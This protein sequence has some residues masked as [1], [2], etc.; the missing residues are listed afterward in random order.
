M[1]KDSL[2]KKLDDDKINLATEKDSLVWELSKLE[3]KIDLLVEENYDLMKLINERNKE[4]VQLTS[5]LNKLNED[6][7]KL[8][9]QLSKMNSIQQVT[10]ND[11]DARKKAEKENKESTIRLKSIDKNM[12]LYSDQNSNYYLNSKDDKLNSLDEDIYKGGSLHNQTK[13]S[14]NTTKNEYTSSLDIQR[15]KLKEAQQK[16]EDILKKQGYYNGKKN[17]KPNDKP[18]VCFDLKDTED[19]SLDNGDKVKNNLEKYTSFKEHL[20]FA[21]L[22]RKK[23]SS[24]SN[25]DQQ[26]STIKEL[27]EDSTNNELLTSKT[28]NKQKM[29]SDYFKKPTNKFILNKPEVQFTSTPLNKN[30]KIK[31]LN[32]DYK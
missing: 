11:T 14:S 29:N 32:Y 16:A 3:K 25:D 13:Y 18:E 28:V 31:K 1:E 7:R 12:K 8:G 21:D 17:T 30:T 26:E 22:E 10:S 20:N 15:K 4:I 2:V 27:D 5:D 6:K 24:K 19:S 9:E 23:L